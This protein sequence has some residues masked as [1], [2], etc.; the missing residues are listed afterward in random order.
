[1]RATAMA[2]RAQSA[3]QRVLNSKDA[4]MAG[5]IFCA[6]LFAYVPALHGGF[7]WDDLSHITKPELRSLHGL[8]RIWFDLGA[9]QQYYPLL[10]SAFWLEYKL[11]GDS[12][13]GYHLANVFLHAFSACLVVMIMR[14]LSLPGAWLGGFIFALH[15]VH[16]EAVAWISEQKSTLS[17]V[18][19]LA[20]LLLY[21]RFDR[22]RHARTYF[23]ALALFA[24]ALA[25]KTV[26]ATLPAALLVIF[27][28]QRGRLD[29]KRDVLPLSP[30]LAL[31]A[32]AGLFTAWVERT[33]IGAQGA[34]YA[35]T[36]L[37]RSLLSGRVI[38]FYIGKLLWPQNLI[39]NYPHWTIDVSQWWQ[40]FFSLSVLATAAG[41][42]LLTRRIRG[43]L[44]A[45]LLF[46]GMLFPVLGFLNVYPFVYS[47]VADHFQY[48]ASVGLIVP[49]AAVLTAAAERIA[50][51]RFV[52]GV[53][54]ALLL[55]VL[56]TQTW[57]QS[58]TYRDVETLYRAILV[59]NPGSILAHNNLGNYLLNT[60][61]KVQEAI[62]Q[63]KAALA[64][65]DDLP[66]AHNNLGLAFTLIPGAQAEAIA[67][68]EAALRSR[69]NYP[70]AHNNL[71]SVLAKIPG[72]EP[73]AIE[74]LKAALELTPN[75]ADA[76]VNLGNVLVNLPGRQAEAIAQFEVALQI[77]NSSANVHNSLG[78][79][80]L[81]IPGRTSEAIL[82]F[83]A[84]LRLKPDFPEAQ[85]NLGGVLANI[86]ERQLQAIPYLEA[87][88]KS[89]PN[90]A[91]AQMNLG[92]AL[93][94]IPDRTADAIS[95]LEEAVGINPELAQAQAL[96][97]ITLARAGRSPEAIAHL[98]AAVRLRPDDADSQVAL[99][100]VLAA[101]P[102]RLAEALQHLET[103][104][105][106]QPDPEVQKVVNQLRAVSEVGRRFGSDP[107]SK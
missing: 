52:P 15:P 64:L 11:W 1:M 28:W 18:F 65:N 6:S 74:H 47:Y 89:N 39:F 12:V 62:A 68:F 17:A 92:S 41:L 94:G 35:L 54:A 102:G 59:R 26:T 27:W 107:L 106:V 66:E 42:Y 69:P 53:A 80:L 93:L 99:G 45:F 61:E 79:A 43:P 71:G 9:T 77:D 76:H 103:A 19:C 37:E 3:P 82:Q 96:L 25:S 48:L 105:K 51:R 31:G 97:G 24:L 16:V 91:E 13:L 90:L 32:T 72:R 4:V 56:A 85:N 81:K 33:Y 40:Y 70:A 63:F 8:W 36:P 2:Q 20:S 73:E 57:R 88:L 34:N 98:E 7:I 104:L 95:H 44:A 83:E 38:W 10:H 75:F 60:P 46:V 50:V 100:L 55:A 87:A 21:L 84:A 22:T 14:R 23:L 67:Q 29:F 86:P 101:V 5:L 78:M 30:W 49:L 58:E